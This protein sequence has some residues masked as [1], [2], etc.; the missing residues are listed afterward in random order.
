MVTPADLPHL[1]TLLDDESPEVRKGVLR[2]FLAFGPEL[3]QELEKLSEPPTPEQKRKLDDLLGGYLESRLRKSWSTWLKLPSD[4]EKLERGF[5]LLS[6][7]Q[8]GLCSSGRLKA[9]LD[10]LA[11]EYRADHPEPEPFSLVTFLFQ[12]KG[13]RG[14]R[15]KYYEPGNSNLV[16]VMTKKTGLPISLACIAILVGHRLGV[17]IQ[18]Y[19]FPGHFLA[20]IPSEPEGVFVD[21]FNGGQLHKES[22]LSE[23]FAEG[24]TSVEAQ[25]YLPASAEAILARVLRNLVGAYERGASS[26]KQALMRNLLSE[27]VKFAGV[28]DPPRFEPGQLVRHKRYGYHGV[29]VDADPSCRAS[30]DWHQS[31][32]TQPVRDQP[33]YHV[34]VS[35]SDACTYAAHENLETDSDGLPVLH[36]LLDHFFTDFREGRYIRNERPW[37]AG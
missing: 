16:E 26:R 1:L 21:C 10:E 8:G 25:A 14:E 27:L 18:G 23:H 17:E 32:R 35:G 28:G 4:I 12:T 6:K 9:L 20:L 31:N 36:P 22:E 13:L 7:Y 11:A 3:E 33:W 5:E 15:E 30:E 24:S 34:L 2:G 19:N 37:R 29:V